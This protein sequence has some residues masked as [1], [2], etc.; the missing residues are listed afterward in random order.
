M[1]CDYVALSSGHIYSNKTNRILKPSDNGRGYQHV[2]LRINGKSID[3]YVHRYIAEHFLLNPYGYTEVNHIDGDKTNNAVENLEWC[4]SS[5]NKYH[6]VKIG[7]INA[8]FVSQFNL[9]GVFLCRYTN[10]KT[11]SH[12]TGVGHQCIRRVCHGDRKQ[13]GGFLWQYS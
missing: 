11:A 1:K 13:A 10:A 8:R 7:L 2:V 5:Q 3:T 6:S 12:Y 9:N 4:T